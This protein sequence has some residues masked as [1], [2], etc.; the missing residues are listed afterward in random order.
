[1][2]I[3]IIKVII[4]LL[5]RECERFHVVVAA[6]CCSSTREPFWRLAGSKTIR[7]SKKKQKNSAKKCR[8][9]MVVDQ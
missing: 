4:I 7:L 9:G 6:V 5:I 2:I 3:S 8:K 1:M